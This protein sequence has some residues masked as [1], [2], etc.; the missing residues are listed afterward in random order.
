MGWFFGD[1]EDPTIVD[2]V[3]DLDESSITV[4]ALKALDYIVPGEWEN[5]T[6]FDELVALVTENDD[7]EYIEQIKEKVIELY[8]DEEENYKSAMKIFTLIDS[9]DTAI[10]AA[11]MAD[12]L[13]DSFSMFSFMDDLTPKAD[14]VQ[15]VDL[16][17]KIVA[18]MVAFALLKGE[19]IE[20]LE[21]FAEQLGAYSG[22]AKM[23]LAA[24]VCFDGMVPLGPDFVGIVIESLQEM[25]SDSLEE[26]E[27]FQRISDYVP[28]DEVETQL[29]FIGQ[30]FENVQDWLQ[31]FM[32]E[33]E[34]SV[35]GILENLREYVEIADDK[36]D[37]VAAFLDMS[38]SYFEHT[39]THTVAVHIIQRAAEEIG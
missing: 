11:A 6:N 25:S 8:N 1:D 29:G 17:L 26:N 31:N 37:Y 33:N 24:L 2:L 9:A 28:G 15:T 36:L 16:A 32:E 23:R 38:T 10:G 12:K 27:T 34:I 18:E 19:D 20:D 3:N 35:E 14:T 7:E 13:A 30:A 4:Y 22:E 21:T 39:G 5:I